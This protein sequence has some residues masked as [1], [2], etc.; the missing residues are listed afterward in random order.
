MKI[1]KPKFWSN[2]KS[3]YSILLAPISLIYLALI[4]IR[5][6]FSNPKKMKI[7][8]ICVGNIY[9]GG[10]GKTPLSIEIVKK[11]NL[12]TKRATVIKKYYKNQKD[13]HE[14]I[15]K[16]TGC[17]TLG[18]NRELALKNAEKKNFKIGVL[19]DG[20]QDH[21]VYKDVNILCFNSKQ[22]VGNGMLLPSGPLREK[23]ECV[24]RAEIVVINGRKDKD[25]EKNINNISKK[26]SIFYSKYIP[27]NISKFKNKKLFAFA[28]IANPENFFD[29]LSEYGLIVKKK[30]IFPDHYNFKKFEL[31][32]MNNYAK[33]KNLQLITTEKD[34]HR[35][36]GYGYKNIRYLELDLKIFNENDLI[37]KILKQIQ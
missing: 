37:K 18:I 35:I 2:K 21:S 30:S 25:F 34:Y 17:L 27:K 9:L 16:K 26:T 31:Q 5:K 19:D 14:L 23:I 28:G 20:F 11:L 32:K 10:T 29:L 13:E 24:R 6:I 8:I 3:L 12:K 1:F 36:K 4:T 7:S 15:K 33:K 22:L